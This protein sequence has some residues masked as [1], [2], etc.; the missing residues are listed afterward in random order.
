MSVPDSKLTR[1][2]VKYLVKDT[3]YF[4][5]AIIVLLLAILLTLLGLSRRMDNDH[6]YISNYLADINPISNHANSST[7]VQE[8]TERGEHS[9]FQNHRLI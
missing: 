6:L 1:H 2:Q 9:S 4:K 7:H 3:P 8:D 5:I